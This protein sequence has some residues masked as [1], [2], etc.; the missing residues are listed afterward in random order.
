MCR[1]NLAVAMNAP[2]RLEQIDYLPIKRSSHPNQ[3]Y[4]YSAVV[5]IVSLIHMRMVDVISNK[6]QHA[7]GFRLA[8]GDLPKGSGLCNRRGADPS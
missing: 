8:G 1:Y 3:L 6:R 2:F 7:T 5:A 4:I